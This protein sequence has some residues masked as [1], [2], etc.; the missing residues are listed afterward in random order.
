MNIF[1]II[2]KEI[3]RKHKKKFRKEHE[4]ILAEKII[5]HY[6]NKKN[7][8]EEENEAVEYLKNN[9]FSIF[10]YKWYN[11]GYNPQSVKVFIDD[12]SGLKYVYQDKKKIYFPRKWKEKKIQSAWNGLLLEQHIQSPHRYLTDSFDITQDDIIID[13]GAAEGN[14]SLSVV[15]KCKKIY[16]FETSLKWI[17]ALEQTFRP[18][19]EKVV[20][21]KKYASDKNTKNEI[22]LDNFFGEN[23]P[24]NLFIKLDVEGAELSV[25]KGCNKL[26]SDCRNIKVAACTYHKQNDPEIISEFLIEKGFS[27]DFSKGFLTFFTD[28]E[29]LNWPYLLRRGILRAIKTN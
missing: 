21:V 29:E 13:V 10:P 9:G 16:L 7:I 19:K 3:K 24:D 26:L 11:D 20:I 12:P 8:T 6:S 27:I 22:T 4:N 25:L 17:E 18:W 5:D 2:K 14:L 23:F 15:E 1:S 28:F